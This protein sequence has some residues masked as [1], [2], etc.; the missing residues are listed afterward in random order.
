MK[1]LSKNRLPFSKY[2]QKTQA[3]LIIDWQENG[4][5]TLIFAVNV[6]NFH[7][8]EIFLNM[9]QRL[10]PSFPKM[11]AVFHFKGTRITIITMNINFELL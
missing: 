11:F 6:E 1:I 7:C 2:R 10:F 4:T 3:P 5:L 9:L 8:Q